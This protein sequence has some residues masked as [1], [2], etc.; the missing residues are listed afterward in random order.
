[1]VPQPGPRYM[2]MQ[3]LPGLMDVHFDYLIEAQLHLTSTLFGRGSNVRRVRYQ[4]R[5]DRYIVKDTWHNV[6]CALTEGQILRVIS[7]VQN[8]PRVVDEYVV[9]ENVF[10]ST[11][12]SRSTL[13]GVP[14][15]YSALQDG[16]FRDRVHPRLLQEASPIQVISKFKSRAEFAHTSMS[17]TYGIKICAN[18]ISGEMCLYRPKLEI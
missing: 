13:L 11:Y 14:E 12:A 7:E 9:S 8:V 15:L 2:A 3:R 5:G 6:A 17:Y 10:S 18:F 16:Q 4:D 1:M